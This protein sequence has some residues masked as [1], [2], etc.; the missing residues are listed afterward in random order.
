MTTHES[1]QKKKL[2][3]RTNS[4]LTQEPRCKVRGSN[5]S[6]GRSRA[7][8][9]PCSNC[10]S[11][12]SN[13]STH[14]L[15]P[16]LP[17]RCHPR[18]TMSTTPA[19]VPRLF[20][21]L[22]LHGARGAPSRPDTLGSEALQSQVSSRNAADT[23]STRTCCLWSWCRSRV[24]ALRQSLSPRAKGGPQEVTADDSLRTSSSMISS[25]TTFR[26]QELIWVHMEKIGDRA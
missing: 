5:S 1:R 8:P 19:C 2:H 3:N 15:C 7:T 23:V 17:R 25:M 26:L 18:H 11:P 20:F 21:G 14:C 9:D 24:D 12:R 22:A 4:L 13:L 16:G 10:S 6:R